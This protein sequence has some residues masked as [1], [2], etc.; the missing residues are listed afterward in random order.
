MAKKY[1]GPEPEIAVTV[2]ICVSSSNPAGQADRVED[3]LRLLPLLRCH[4][5]VGAQAGGARAD[6][7]WR[8][9]HAAHDGQQIA[10]P[11]FQLIDAHARGNRNQQADAC[12][13]GCRAVRHGSPASS[14]ASPPAR[15]TSA[16]AAAKRFSA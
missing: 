4:A 10:K 3:V 15:S 7:R 9:G 5:Q 12:V 11:A 6:Q 2:S 8:V 1:A 14:G 16:S 13:A